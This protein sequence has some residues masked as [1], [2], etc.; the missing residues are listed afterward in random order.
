MTRECR[1]TSRVISGQFHASTDGTRVLNYAEWI[2][3]DAHIQAL[4]KSGMGPSAPGRSG[5]A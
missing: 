3:K 1:S 4:A 5:S 2:N